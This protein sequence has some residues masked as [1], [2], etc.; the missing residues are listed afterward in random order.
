MGNCWLATA[1]ICLAPALPALPACLLRR[2]PLI[3][4]TPPWWWESASLVSVPSEALPCLSGWQAGRQ[5]AR[6]LCCTT[7]LTAPHPCL[8]GSSSTTARSP[9]LLP[10]LLQLGLPPLWTGGSI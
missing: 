8:N 5:P 1:E 9:V 7:N 4:T 10:G 3:A 2:C 6:V